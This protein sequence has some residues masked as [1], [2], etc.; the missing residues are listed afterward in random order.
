[1]IKKEEKSRIFGLCYYHVTIYWI[2]NIRKKEGNLRSCP[3]DAFIN[4]GS[5]FAIEICEELYREYPPKKYT[6][7]KIED[8]LKCPVTQ[9]NFFI[10][11]HQNYSE[12]K[13]EN[14]WL[15]LHNCVG[16]GIYI[17]WCNAHPTVCRENANWKKMLLCVILISIIL[18]KRNI[19]R[20]MLTIEKTLI[21]E[22]FLWRI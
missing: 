13:G 12:V 18:N 2:T 19:L 17:V 9:N 11:R 10:H 14:K 22:L 6:N 4:A 15:L 8:I 20:Q 21:W 1:M 5:I 7:S 16:T 3:H